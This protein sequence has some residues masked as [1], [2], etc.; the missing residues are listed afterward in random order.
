MAAVR[1]RDTKPELLVRRL[2][3][4]MGYRF[5]LNVRSLPGSPDI[6]FPR[7]DKVIFVHGCFWHRHRCKRATTPATRRAFWLKKFAE[8]KERDRRNIRALQRAG[9]DVLVVWECWTRRPEWLA[10]RLADFLRSHKPG[11][12]AHPSRSDGWG[13]D[14]RMPKA[15]GKSTVPPTGPKSGSKPAPANPSP[16]TTPSLPAAS[17][18]TSA[19]SPTSSA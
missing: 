3:H 7:L 1:Q 2:A 16:P 14:D 11:R 6:V 4:R 10:R 5:R 15:R 18:S 19:S 12:V 13:H 8:N 17:K 9:W